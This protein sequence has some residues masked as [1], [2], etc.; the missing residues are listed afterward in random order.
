[1]AGLGWAIDGLV[2]NAHYDGYFLPL[3]PGLLERREVSANI[4]RRVRGAVV[5]RQSNQQSNANPHQQ[6]SL[7]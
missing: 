5:E 7:G 3:D 1:M 6:W 4:P 2:V